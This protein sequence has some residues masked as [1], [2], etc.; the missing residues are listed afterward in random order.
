MKKI[1]TIILLAL[2]LANVTTATETP[3]ITNHIIICDD[4][5][6]SEEIPATGETI[7]SGCSPFLAM[8]EE[9]GPEEPKE[10]VIIEVPVIVSDGDGI[11]LQCQEVKQSFEI[12]VFNWAEVLQG[13]ALPGT[14]IEAEQLL[15][16]YDEN[17]ETRSKP[18]LR[19]PF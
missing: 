3:V 4:F 17:R 5:D 7:M 18:D 12:L 1:A 11:D 19:Q 14:E 8:F 15:F 9:T 6:I 2:H 16:L 13:Q 10:N